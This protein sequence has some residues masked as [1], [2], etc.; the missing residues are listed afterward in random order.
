M[1]AGVFVWKALKAVGNWVIENPNLVYDKIAKIP[2]DKKSLDD[3]EY[4]Q[5]IDAKV[6]QLGAAA[7]ELEEKINNENEQLRNDL[8]A[9]TNQL[10]TTKKIVS[11]MGVV[12]GAAIIAIALLAI[13]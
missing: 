13:L 12:L 7:L 3:K 1:S 6:N 2:S 9:L 11:I 5:T 8:A 4:L 10:Q